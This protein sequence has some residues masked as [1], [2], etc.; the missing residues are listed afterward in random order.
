MSVA[1]ALLLVSSQ[2]ALVPGEARGVIHGGPDEAMGMTSLSREVKRRWCW[3]KRRVQAAA[4]QGIVP[5]DPRQW[6]LSHIRGS[7]GVVSNSGAFRSN[8]LGAA[9][10]RQDVV[11]RFNDAPTRGFEAQVGAKTTVRFKHYRTFLAI[12]SGDEEPEEGVIYIFRWRVHTFAAF[13]QGS[14][15]VAMEDVQRKFPNSGIFLVTEKFEDAVMSALGRLYPP[16]WAPQA[17]VNISHWRVLARS[18]CPTMGALGMVMALS[19]CTEVTAFEMVP[20][21]FAVGSPY[22][23]YD[24]AARNGHTTLNQEHDLWRSVSSTPEDEIL[25]TG[26]ARLPGFNS[27][28]C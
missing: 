3:L 2:V 19:V 5:A 25:E 14:V 15:R 1:L 17:A 18:G 28:R 6:S 23:Y 26:V 24:D 27:S 20:S 22:Q 7:C 16:D 8:P 10:D 13:E 11:M 21:K 9:I 12:L 4:L